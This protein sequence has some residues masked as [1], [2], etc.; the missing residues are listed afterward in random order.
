MYKYSDSDRE[1]K[2][3]YSWTLAQV[4]RAPKETG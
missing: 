1:N 2:F 3:V 4:D